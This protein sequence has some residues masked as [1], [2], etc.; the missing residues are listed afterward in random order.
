MT[1]IKL[2]ANPNLIPEFKPS[3]EANARLAA[4]RLTTSPAIS[5]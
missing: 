3:V 4:S 2:L 5:R 1:C